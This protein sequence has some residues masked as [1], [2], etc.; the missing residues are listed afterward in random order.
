MINVDTDMQIPITHR[1]H[2][3]F[4]NAVVDVDRCFQWIEGWAKRR[5]GGGPNAVTL[6][7]RHARYACRECVDKL[8]HDIAIGQTQLF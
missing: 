1:V 6:A 8:Q 3:E 4:C 2:C 5:K 7:A